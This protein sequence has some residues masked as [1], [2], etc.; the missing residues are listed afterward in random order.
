MEYIDLNVVLHYEDEGERGGE[1][2]EAEEVEMDFEREVEQGAETNNG[3][4]RE[5][6]GVEGEGVD[7]EGVDGEGV[8]GEGV[9]GE[10]VE[11]EGV[12]GV[13]ETGL[14]TTIDDIPEDEFLKMLGDDVMAGSHDHNVT[15]DDVTSQYNVKESN[16]PIDIV[17]DSDDVI[18]QSHDQGKLLA[19][20]LTPTR[21]LALQVQAHI[22]AA[23]K[24]TGIRV[25]ILI[26]TYE[27]S[28]ALFPT[29]LIFMHYMKVILKS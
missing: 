24:Y 4:G 20:I 16:D 28:K 9:D 29:D 18:V 14:V 3:R 26:G 13:R 8:E 19:L 7:D 1:E 5:S 22:T 17:A 10:S 2:E 6:E 25:S 12:E 27:P 11:G 15:D 23:A 21:E